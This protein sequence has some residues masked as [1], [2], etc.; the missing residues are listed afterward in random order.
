MSRN[1]ILS[2]TVLVLLIAWRLWQV[3]EILNVRLTDFDHY[4]TAAVRLIA[5]EPIYFDDNAA[6]TRPDIPTWYLYPPYFAAGIT[7]LTILGRQGAG[8]V[9][10]F[11]SLAALI[12]IDRLIVLLHR[13]M[14]S[15]ES[16]Y[17]WLIHLV[18]F[19]PYPTRLL[20]YSM[21]IDGVMFLIFLVL[22]VL[23]VGKDRVWRM[24]MGYAVSVSIKLWPGPFF[25]TLLAVCR[26]R[27]WFPVITSFLILIFFFTLFFGI[28]PQ[29]YFLRYVLPDLLVYSD[30]YIDNQSLFAC[31]RR[32]AP[33]LETVYPLCQWC[34]LALYGYVTYRSRLAL[35]RRNVKTIAVNASF[36]SL[37]SI[38]L[39]PTAWTAAHVRLLLP[40]ATAFTLALE[41]KDR[42]PSIA[43]TTGIALLFYIYP[44]SYAR[45]LNPFVLLRD[46][47]LLIA[48]MILFVM[49]FILSLNDRDKVSDPR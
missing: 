2:H 38:L 22:V 48:T 44:Q 6:W 28:E 15:T 9:F 27:I 5:G 47:P 8:I 42:S 10:V 3:P 17:E 49:F 45:G 30:S 13:R 41:R 24:G 34:L 32:F 14:L 25:I 31:L 43:V 4:Y 7:I 40:L 46:Y 19:V 37:V 18:V 1:A 39:S 23:L 26:K 33:K 12:A 16:V 11:L 29:W 36:F 21:Q 20:L 35:V